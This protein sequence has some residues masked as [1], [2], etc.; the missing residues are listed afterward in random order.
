MG[1]GRGL[2]DSNIFENE[3]VSARLHFY[4]ANDRHPPHAHDQASIG[5][6]LGGSL[7][8][9]VGGSTQRGALGA[10]I[11]KPAGVVHQND[12]G[13]SGTIILSIGGAYVENLA[14]SM[15]EWRCADRA[16]AHA[17]AAIGHARGG[18][19]VGCEEA[20][21]LMLSHLGMPVRD[22]DSCARVPSWLSE[23]MAIL[24]QQEASVRISDV[25]ARVGV[26]PVHL[27]RVF[28]KQFGSSLSRHIRRNKVAQAAELLRSSRRRVCDVAA[29]LEFFDQSHLCRAFKAECGV[30]PSDYRRL[31]RHC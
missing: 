21:Y 29:E 23:V 11:V 14:R 10:V 18:R 30:S 12:F 7:T 15:W 19:R 25:A 24:G 2:D 22:D 9:R 6:L 8:E 5:I 28:Q 16:L 31:T 26:H 1:E 3:E 4:P 13:E 20:L 17:I 27:T